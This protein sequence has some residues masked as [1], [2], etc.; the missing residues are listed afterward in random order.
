[1]TTNLANVG[2]AGQT[3]RGHEGSARIGEY[4]VF[5]KQMTREAGQE[6]AWANAENEQPDSLKRRT[7]GRIVKSSIR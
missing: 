4:S 3:T 6:Y 5:A 2:V 1:M 7:R